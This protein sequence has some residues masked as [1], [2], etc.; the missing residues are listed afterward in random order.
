MAFSVRVGTRASALARAQS[1][2]V[3]EQLAAALPGDG[4]AVELVLV[5]TEGDRNLAP[6]TQIGGAGVFVTAVR[7]ALLE[8]RCDVAVHSL[9]DL[10][11]LA[12][13]GLEIGAIPPR[14]DPRDALCARGGHTLAS[15]PP[16]ARV[17]TGSPR[18][19]AQLRQSRPDLEIVDVR[20]NVDTRLRRVSED[21]DAVV[22]ARAGLARLGRLDAVTEVLADDLL[23]P[24]PGQGALAVECRS[25][26][27]AS[28][29]P[30]AAALAAL[31]HEPTRLAVTAERAMLA[32]LEV[33]C[34]APVGALA[35]S[36]DGALCLGTAVFVDSLGSDALRDV[37]GVHAVELPPSGDLAARVAA[38]IGLGRRAAE[39]SLAR[40]DRA[41]IDHPP[42]EQ[43]QP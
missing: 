33:G 8:G 36:E 1:A 4:G 31:D 40:I 10:P 13:P 2:W 43:V 5:S 3:G 28:G 35:R 25:A 15:L 18:R 11:T 37:G 7:E 27:L 14:E 12:C 38:A 16:G 22:L 24:A 32:R 34:S 17:G 21:L 42:T 26:D 20:G 19:A 9:K 23:I 39:E 6:L 41:R 30:L 29:S